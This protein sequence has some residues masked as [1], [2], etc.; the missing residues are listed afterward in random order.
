MHFWVAEYD[1]QIV[2]CVGVTAGRD[3]K[4]KIK[5]DEKSANGKD[6]TDNT[7]NTGSNNN[8]NTNSSSS[9][10]D[11]SNSKVASVWR[12]TV[13]PKYRRYGIGKLLMDVVEKYLKE[14]GFDEIALLAGNIDSLKFYDRIGYRRDRV[15]WHLGNHESIY[16][17]K[18]I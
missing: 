6:N 9:A 2:G 5:D 12:L 11:S 1:K 3:L 4:P 7:S 17:S 14:Q 13:D 16:Y 18:K 15:A 8:N 10:D